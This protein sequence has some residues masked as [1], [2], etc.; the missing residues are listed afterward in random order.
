M[1]LKTSSGNQKPTS[2]KG[3]IHAMKKQTKNI[4]QKPKSNW[5]IMKTRGSK[6]KALR[7]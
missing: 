7:F 6:I 2:Q 5:M 3:A 1:E 4:N